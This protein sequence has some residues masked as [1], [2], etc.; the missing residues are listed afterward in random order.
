MGIR[1][2]DGGYSSE[3]EIHLIIEGR[4]LPVSHIESE[5]LILRTN[6]IVPNGHAQ[7]S[8]SVDGREEIHD[9]IIHSS[10]PEASELTYA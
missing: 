8:I 7:I 2:D 9:V 10:N 4:R 3:V 6:E 5:S 1:W